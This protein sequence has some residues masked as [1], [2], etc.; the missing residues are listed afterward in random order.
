MSK[1]LSEITKEALD[2]SAS[3]R[4]TLARILI[5]LSDSNDDFS[6][7]VDEEW[8]LEITRRLDLVRAGRAQSRPFDAVMADVNR[9]F[10][11]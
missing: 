2:L 1:A 8:D 3:Q 4:L 9:R 6:P 7:A 11:A 5:E 10:A